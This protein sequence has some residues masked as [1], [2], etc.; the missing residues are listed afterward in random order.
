MVKEKYHY[1]GI[2]KL[3]NQHSVL[4]EILEKRF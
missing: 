3:N 2:K 1:S 4:C